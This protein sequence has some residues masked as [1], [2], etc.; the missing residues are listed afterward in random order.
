M[1]KELLLLHGQAVRRLARILVK[2]L[3]VHTYTYATRKV[4]VSNLLH[5]LNV[6]AGS[7]SD[8]AFQN[9]YTKVEGDLNKGAGGKYIYVCYTKDQSQLHSIRNISAIAGGNT[10][11]EFHTRKQSNQFPMRT[12]QWTFNRKGHNFRTTRNFHYPHI[13]IT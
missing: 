12:K 11:E 8:F 4:V 10:C 7:L 1:V 5:G 6:F 3:V 2:E 13:S 9:G